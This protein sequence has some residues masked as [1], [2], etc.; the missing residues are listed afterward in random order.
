M[1]LCLQPGLTGKTHEIKEA[2]GTL[3]QPGGG[4]GGGLNGKAVHQL[5]APCCSKEGL[6][7]DEILFS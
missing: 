6:L 7:A 5:Q 3:D 2:P 1:L 4:W